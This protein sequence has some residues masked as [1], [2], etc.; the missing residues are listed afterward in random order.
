MYQS[1]GFGTALL[2]ALGA[3]ASGRADG[4]YLQVAPDN[5]VARRTHAAQGFRLLHRY[6]YLLAP[7][8]D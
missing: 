5:D 2:P 7:A 1:R 3:W 8:D 6:H 4:V